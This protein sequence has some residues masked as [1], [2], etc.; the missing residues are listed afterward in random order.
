MSWKQSPRNKKMPDFRSQNNHG[1]GSRKNS[2]KKYYSVNN[3]RDEWRVD[4][5]EYRRDLQRLTFTQFCDY[6]NATGDH[7]TSLC[8]STNKHQPC[9]VC[10]GLDHLAQNCPNIICAKCNKKHHEKFCPVPTSVLHC[11]QC[12]LTGHVDKFCPN[13]WRQFIGITSLPEKMEGA[14][15][16]VPYVQM[17]KNKNCCICGSQ[18]HFF[19]VS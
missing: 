5:I 19:Y 11:E 4:A 16:S 18:Q 13:N 2:P 9:F 6:C 1:M 17:S 8:N 7:P 14:E 3:L 15:I 10:A 12:N